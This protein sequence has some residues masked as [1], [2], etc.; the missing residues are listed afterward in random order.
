[1]TTARRPTRCDRSAGSQEVFLTSHRNY[2]FTICA[3]YS[4][5]TRGRSD[6]LGSAQ[7]GSLSQIDDR[8]DVSRLDL[9]LG[10]PTAP[11]PSFTERTLTDVPRANISD[12]YRA[13]TRSVKG[14][15]YFDISSSWG[16]LET[17]QQSSW[18]LSWTLMSRTSG[19]PGLWRWTLRLKDSWGTVRV[20]CGSD[21]PLPA[22]QPLSKLS[23]QFAT[24]PAPAG[25][26]P[27]T[28]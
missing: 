23:P 15:V 22:A 24:Y 6:E 2:A 25:E 4:A 8:L 13:I 27:C 12:F 5:L 3:H 16:C 28:A 20:F 17:F 19:G 21:T 1:M 10:I 11:V 14:R 26:C 9:V 7:G 18:A